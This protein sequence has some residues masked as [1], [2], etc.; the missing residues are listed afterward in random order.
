MAKHPRKKQKL[1]DRKQAT[2]LL[3]SKNGPR[4]EEKDEEE[5]R[6]ESLVFDSSFKSSDR[7]LE[8]AGLDGV[9]GLLVDDGTNDGDM[10]HLLDS[11]VR[12]LVYLLPTIA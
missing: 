12:T 3:G 2:A 8:A 11:E 6:L 10:T 4:F 7:L 5:R 9:D 1:N